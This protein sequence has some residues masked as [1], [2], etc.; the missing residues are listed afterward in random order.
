[1]ITRDELSNFLTDYLKLEEAPSDSSWNGLQFEGR[2]EVQKVAFAVDASLDSFMAA[3]REDA[4]FLI[5]HHG[6]FWNGSN[7][8]YTGWAKKRLDY[9]YQHQLSLYAAHL[10]LDRHKE[11]GNNAQ[12]LKLLG[13]E[14]TGEFMVRD[15]KNIGWIGTFTAPKPLA[16]IRTILV[17]KLVTSVKTLDF[18][19]ELVKTI[20][21]CTGGGGY[22][23]FM[24]A[25][26]TNVDLYISGD[27]VEIYSTAKDA[28]MNVIF[29]GHNTTETVG[30]LALEKVIQKK[31]K[32]ETVF[33]DLPTGL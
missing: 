4:D 25:L 13:A 9:L 12:I 26:N 23:G 24:E 33:I 28:E 22:H 19:K 17:E 30:L 11:V 10:P 15:G 1:M 16:E 32:V 29:A 6:H 8:T 14:I 21:V 20:A 27:A 31:F 5:V 3:T 18:G 2:D 7:P